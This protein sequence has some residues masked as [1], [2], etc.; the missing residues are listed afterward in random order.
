MTA[1][2]SVISSRSEPP[3]LLLRSAKVPSLGDRALG[4]GGGA[5]AAT[6]Q[7]LAIAQRVISI[8]ERPHEPKER[9]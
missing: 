7:C 2:A 1:V 3:V 5:R 4:R 9:I 6:L 8:G